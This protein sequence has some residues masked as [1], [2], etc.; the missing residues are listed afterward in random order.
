MDRQS[1][2]TQVYTKEPVPPSDNSLCTTM[3]DVWWD[4][5]G[6][7]QYVGKDMIPRGLRI[8]KFPSTLYSEEFTL[9]RNNILTK[10]SVELMELIIQQE[11][12]LL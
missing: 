10:C 11:E 7:K 5:T 2:I 3:F 12:S 1:K 9:Q 4:L 6:L 8:K